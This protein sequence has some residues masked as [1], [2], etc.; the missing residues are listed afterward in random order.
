MFTTTQPLDI[1]GGAKATQAFML[2]H[3]A[4]VASVGKVSDTVLFKAQRVLVGTDGTITPVG[5]TIDKGFPAVQ[6][7]SARA[8]NPKLDAALTA[9]STA[10]DSIAP[11]LGL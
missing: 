9:I 3:F 1:G 11:E 10:L 7:A 2:I 4:P 6:L 8:A 5:P